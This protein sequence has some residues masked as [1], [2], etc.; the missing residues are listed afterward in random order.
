MSSAFNLSNPKLDE[1]KKKLINFCENEVAPAQKIFE[2]H[3]EENALKYKGNRFA[4]V[5]PVIE[6]LKKKAKALGLWNLW[7]P[8]T[9]LPLGAGLTNLE[10]AQLAEI[11]GR[12]RIVSYLLF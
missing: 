9:Y 12:Y 7:M 10:Y 1:L 8:K 4:T 5:P 11:M 2:K 6:D 3:I